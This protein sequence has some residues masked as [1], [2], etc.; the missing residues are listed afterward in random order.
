[1]RL[2]IPY[3]CLGLFA[4]LLSLNIG[5]SSSSNMLESG[6]DTGFDYAAEDSD[7][8]SEDVTS[9]PEATDTALPI[10]P[11]YWTLDGSVELVEGMAD[12]IETQLSISL[13]LDAPEPFCTFDLPAPL[14]DAEPDEEAAAFFTWWEVAVLD[15]SE[16]C[17]WP[18]V[19][20]VSFGIGPMDPL[21]DPALA[22]EG[23]P[24]ET[25]YALY[26]TPGKDEPVFVYGVAGTPDQY[27]SK[28][29][30][31]VIEAPPLPDGSYTLQALHLLPF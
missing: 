17:Y 14:L 6:G 23:L 31:E 21:L 26:L 8:G 29:D 27:A 15:E 16:N 19:D 13:W 2:S 20:R 12:P 4:G 18:G 11:D 1:M 30:F 25:L 10:T 5:C 3:I 22:A 24:G 9:A 28:D 7:A